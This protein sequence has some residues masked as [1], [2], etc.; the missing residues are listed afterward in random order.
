MNAGELAKQHPEGVFSA[1][2]IEFL[3]IRESVKAP[4][5]FLRAKCKT[6]HGV[7]FASLLSTFQALNLIR[8]C[9]TFIKASPVQ[10][11][12]KHRPRG[13]EIWLSVELEGFYEHRA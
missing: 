8:G 13:E 6:E 12:V 1:E 7:V 4:F 11:R 2:L 5:C 10:V 3:E 9:E